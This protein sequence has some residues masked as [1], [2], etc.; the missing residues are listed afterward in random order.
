MN[1]TGFFCELASS[2]VVY[3]SRDCLAGCPTRSTWARAGRVSGC[4]E[5]LVQHFEVLLWA[6][7]EEIHLTVKDSGLGFDSEGAKK[8]RGHG[9]ISVE[10]GLKLLQGT[11]S[12]E[13][14]LQ[15]GTTIHA[16]V[17]LCSG[18]DSMGAAG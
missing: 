2:I 12:I 14:Q 7:S 15:G 3:R 10:E 1:I 13:P 6:T 16:R 8:S 11:L 17:P 4:T 9:L 5:W 18:S